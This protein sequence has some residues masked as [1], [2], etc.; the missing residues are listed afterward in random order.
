[1]NI[2][3]ARNRHADSYIVES[4]ASSMK[5]K[6]IRKT[7]IPKM[8]SGN[9]KAISQRLKIS[10]NHFYYSSK[11]GK[12]PCTSTDTINLVIE[13]YRSPQVSTKFPNKQRNNK[14]LHVMK[15]TQNKTYRVFIGEYPSINIGL[16]TF[17]QLR[18]A[19]IKLRKFAKWQQCL[20]DI[21]DENDVKCYQA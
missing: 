19:G 20:W 18:P 7:L 10:R 14:V 5:E 6:V 16:S 11:K 15:F 9:K 4:T 1:M 17:N 3:K 12:N 21:C 13:F 2:I 8:A